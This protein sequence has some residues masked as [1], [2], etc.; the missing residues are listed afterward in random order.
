MDVEITIRANIILKL[1]K[2]ELIETCCS[3]KKKTNKKLIILFFIL[4]KFF[5]KFK[6]NN[7]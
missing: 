3:K 1:F 2:F 6:T 5:K 7:L 4:S